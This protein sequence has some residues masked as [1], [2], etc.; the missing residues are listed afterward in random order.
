ME[1]EHYVKPLSGTRPAAALWQLSGPIFAAR[2]RLLQRSVVILQ[3]LRSWQSSHNSGYRLSR[4]VKIEKY[5][6]V[7]NVA[8]EN[9]A[10]ERIAVEYIA[11]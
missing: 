4:R 1:D 10:V 2:I 5:L 11:A 8:V 7:E 6:V 3:L 9:V